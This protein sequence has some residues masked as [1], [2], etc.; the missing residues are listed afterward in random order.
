MIQFLSIVLAAVVIA[1]SIERLRV[2]LSLVPSIPALKAVLAEERDRDREVIAAHLAKAAVAI[3]AYQ[4]QIEE[5]LRAMIGEEQARA[6][7]AERKGSAAEGRARQADQRLLDA[8]TALVTAVELVGE[9]RSLGGELRALLDRL[10]PDDTRA[11]EPGTGPAGSSHRPPAQSG[12]IPKGYME[13][14]SVDGDDELT[15]ANRERP[16]VQ[17][18]APRLALP[19]P[20]PGAA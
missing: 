20:A 2:R 12:A 19:P 6:Y 9:V 15:V 11:T 1:Y 7:T 4:K 3:D 17:P 14:D 8:N 18:P 5:K 13:G 10:T 16:T